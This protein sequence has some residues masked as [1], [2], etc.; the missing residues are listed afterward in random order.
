MY[1]EENK[2]FDR[3]ESS[4][5]EEIKEEVKKEEIING[6][7]EEKT[8]TAEAETKAEEDVK[9]ESMAE[10]AEEAKA[11]EKAETKPNHKECYYKETVKH[12]KKK[13]SFKRFIAAC[14][15]VSL[16]GGI[17]VGGSYSLVQNY[18][19]NKNAAQAESSQTGTEQTADGSSSKGNVSLLSSG[20][21]D[22]AV[23]VIDKVYPSV[24]N[25]NT[26]V[27]TTA[28]YYGMAVPYDS[29][30]AGSGVIFNEDTL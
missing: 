7:A 9:D 26:S 5:Q 24:V 23:S 17:G 19:N 13:S 12:S 14:M 1:D 27:H 29:N 21:G 22:D 28:N 4:A 6:T 2:E 16:C 10:R 25:I 15:V 8:E 20:N 11:E 30:G 3:T 18:L